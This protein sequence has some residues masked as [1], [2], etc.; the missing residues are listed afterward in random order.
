MRD[1]KHLS[2]AECPLQKGLSEENGR[3]EGFFAKNYSCSLWE[4]STSS[5]GSKFVAFGKKAGSRWEVS[6]LL[7]YRGIIF[8]A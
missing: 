2:H 1:Q 8:A 5:L 4:V 6:W 3:D 7:S